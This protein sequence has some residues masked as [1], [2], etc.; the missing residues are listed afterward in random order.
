MK[1]TVKSQI[2]FEK[3]QNKI[4]YDKANSKVKGQLLNIT[5]P[6]LKNLNILF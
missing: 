2:I 6:F 1:Y 4:K 5:I 3:I